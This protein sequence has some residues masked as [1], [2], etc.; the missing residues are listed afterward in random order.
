MTWRQRKFLQAPTSSESSK[1]D[2]KEAL[3]ETCMMPLCA[4]GSCRMR[5]GPAVWVELLS[6]S[7]AQPCS[8]SVQRRAASLELQSTEAHCAQ[9]KV[10]VCV[11]RLQPVRTQEGDASKYRITPP[12]RKCTTSPRV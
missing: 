10:G 8:L 6:G 2:V 1:E 12:G 11:W 5:N 4:S 7:A 3:L 9:V